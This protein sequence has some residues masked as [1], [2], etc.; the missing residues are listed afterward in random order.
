MS[1]SFLDPN[2]FPVTLLISLFHSSYNSSEELKAL[3]N[4]SIDAGHGQPLFLLG[5]P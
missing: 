1:S 5:L 2:N 3:F 4:I